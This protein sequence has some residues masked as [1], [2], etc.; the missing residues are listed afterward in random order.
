MLKGFAEQVVSGDGADIFCRLGGEGSPL[1]LLH[2]YPETGAMWAP[3][4][5]RLAK[6]FSL[7]IPDLRG[8][9]RSSVPD[10]DAENHA[11][12]KR[13]M[14][15]DMVAVMAALGHR[16]FAVAGHD[17]GGR[18]A[19]RMALDNPDLLTRLAVLDILPVA[20]V[21]EAMGAKAAIKTYHWP[22]LAQPHPL[23]E[24]LIAADPVFYLRHTMASWTKAQSLDAFSPSAMAEY[25]AAFAQPE[26]VHGACNDYR[27]GATIDWRLDRED[28]EAG[29]KI[30]VP[31]LALW[32]T[33]GIPGDGASPLAVWRRWCTQV[34]GHAVDA[35]HFIVE[36]APGETL[37]AL[38]RF[39]AG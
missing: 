21:W 1:L 17:R 30:A 29:R 2:G 7:V 27:A 9:G 31:T 33:A 19:Y 37:E 38:L 3:I 5:D 20:E 35:G 13:Q 34:D 28:R 25:A 22:F 16:Q 8:Y 23:P 12:S 26:H 14:A 15:R 4:A 24:T 32:G 10:N 11:Y 39:F 18:V 6:R 36:E